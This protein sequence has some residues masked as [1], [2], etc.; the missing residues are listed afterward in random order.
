VL[1]QKCQSSRSHG[2]TEVY[3]QHCFTKLLYTAFALH[4]LHCIALRRLTQQRSAVALIAPMFT[5]WL[6]CQH[7]MCSNV[8]CVT[9][10]QCF[11]S[12]ERL[13]STVGFHAGTAVNDCHFVCIARLLFGFIVWY[14]VFFLLR[15]IQRLTDQLMI[16]WLTDVV[17]IINVV[18]DLNCVCY[19]W[20]QTHHLHCLNDFIE[21]QAVYYAQC[22]Q[23]M[24]DLQKQ[25]GRF[26][27]SLLSRSFH[28]NLAAF[29]F[30][31]AL[32]FPT[33]WVAAY[34]LKYHPRVWW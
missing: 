2:R 15:L 6:A 21:A 9:A 7:R 19:I 8:D 25:L 34:S 31:F 32:L 13:V 29:L 22:H 24:T 33:A 1:R 30:V 23:Y 4:C 10:L 3:D 5:F 17:C 14:L 18:S 16:T 26:V 28:A 11:A 12:L 27:A 20:L